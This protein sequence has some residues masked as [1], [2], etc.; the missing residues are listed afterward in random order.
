MINYQ[1]KFNIVPRGRDISLLNKAFMYYTLGVL[2]K[3]KYSFDRDTE[4]NL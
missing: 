1:W 3:G 4:E 2:E